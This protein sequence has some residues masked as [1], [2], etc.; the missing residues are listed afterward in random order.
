MIHW[1]H[2]LGQHS[3]AS[4]HG[5]FEARNQPIFD[6]YAE[7]LDANT[8]AAPSSKYYSFIQPSSMES[9]HMNVL[10]FD[11]LGR[12]RSTIHTISLESHTLSRWWF[13]ANL[14]SHLPS[15][16]EKSD[17]V[18]VIFGR[19]SIAIV[20][21]ENATKSGVLARRQFSEIPH[22]FFTALPT[23]LI[24]IVHKVGWWSDRF[25]ESNETAAGRHF[26]FLSSRATS[27]STG[28]LG[29]IPRRRIPSGSNKA[30]SRWNIKM[31]LFIN[32]MVSR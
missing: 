31:V 30:I 20:V 6:T 21:F 25:R 19:C 7:L 2:R 23:D 12:V 3:F 14:V 18:C 27:G 24:A 13:Q 15:M 32:T 8:L 11:L 16:N 26:H 10:I 17:W 9:S 28:Q 5:I 4:F 22:A 1:I 29:R